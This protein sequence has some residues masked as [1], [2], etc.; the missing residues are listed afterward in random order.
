[1]AYKV[2]DIVFWATTSA[3][4]EYTVIGHPKGDKAGKVSVLAMAADIG[5]EVDADKCA[6][7]GHSN[8]QGCTRWLKLFCDYGGVT[9]IFPFL[10]PLG[11]PR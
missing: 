3:A 10:S 11:R 9:S 6:P 5:F 1:M 4:G 8:P 2:G 7:T